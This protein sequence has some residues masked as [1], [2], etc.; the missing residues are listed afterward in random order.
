MKRWVGG[1]LGEW[2]FIIKMGHTVAAF[3]DPKR[4]LMEAM[5]KSQNKY[6]HTER[7]KTLTRTSSVPTQQGC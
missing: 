1:W 5:A 7:G 3:V 4:M 6:N 2:G